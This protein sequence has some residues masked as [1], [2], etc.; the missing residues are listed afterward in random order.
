[1]SIAPRVV[2]VTQ[3]MDGLGLAVLM[4]RQGTDVL[5]AVAPDERSPEDRKAVEAT[6]DGL[7]E[8]MP[9]ARAIT[10]YAG[11]NAIWLFDDNSLP[12]QADALRNKGEAVLGTSALSAKMETDRAYAAGLAEEVGFAMPDTQEFS[13]TGKAVA[14]LERHPGTAYVCKAQGGDAD[15][16]FVPLPADPDRAANEML[17]GYLASLEGRKGA[18]KRFILQERIAG[19]IEVNVDLALH[20]G[21]PL[22]A[23]VDLESK[24]RLTGDLGPMVGCAQDLVWTAPLAS[25]LVRQTAGRFLGRPELRDYT[26]RVDANVILKDGK[27]YWLEACFDEQTEILTRDG[28][29]P[30][31][32]VPIGTRVATLNRATHEL[33]YQE[34]TDLIRQPYTGDMVHVGGS[35]CSV[36]VLATP[37]HRFYV[38]R[39]VGA[40]AKFSAWGDV[41]ADELA[42]G[43]VL[44]R[45]AV[46]RGHD[47]PH[48]TIPG[49]ATRHGLGWHGGHY[50]VVHPEIRVAMDDWLRFLG[51]YIAEGSHRTRETVQIAQ[52]NHP[53]EV[54]EVLSRLPFAYRRERTGFYIC[55]LQ[56]ARHLGRAP[57]HEK[58]VPGYVKELCP[59]QIRVFLEAYGRGD[60]TR[61][62]RTG[63]VSYITCSPG[64]AADLQELILKAGWCAN[65]AHKAAAGAAMNVR[66]KTYHRRHDRYSVSERRES[67]QFR[68]VG[69]KHL[70]R[71]P[72]SGTVSCVSVPN[73][74]IYVRRQGKAA[75]VSNCWREGY[76]S[77]DT[78]FYGLAT[79]D[80]ERILGAWLRGDPLG[81]FFASRYAASLT[82]FTQQ[83][84]DGFPVIVPPGVA[85]AFSP[86][87][88]RAGDDGTLAMAGGAQRW[89]AVGCLVAA[90]PTARLAAGRCLDLAR[91]ITY[92]NKAHRTD[93]ADADLP[94]LPLA[95]LAALQRLGLVAPVA[96]S[97][98]TDGTR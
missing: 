73:Q 74:T 68:I 57:A 33:E 11:A 97:R 2:V 16:T 96:G 28:W 70:R 50:P 26:G 95:R 82:L 60:G 76:N 13:D 83:N 56:L 71:V 6:G 37:N 90:G 7:V 25:R 51:W 14:Y 63:Q 10:R 59:R 67:G 55:S 64:L 38:R 88:V 24:R 19:G 9:L 93:L 32:D 65:V 69:R 77:S 86:Y 87:A 27:A 18:A 58:R 21:R 4:D 30:I 34:T 66:G 43:M 3:E 44:K 72:Y 98:R 8:K 22:A 79:A 94:T 92:P 29:R 75:W 85:G 15:L 81:G 91:R 39:W 48:H 84:E 47:V 61:H 78:T 62:K 89:Y 36:D 31:K 52:F 40:G 1:M 17:R 49:Y 80:L 45:D 46:W 41:R 12:D 54:E 20:R 5:V 35:G 42:S 23:F 53:D